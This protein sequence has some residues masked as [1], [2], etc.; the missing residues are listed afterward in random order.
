[1][2]VTRYHRGSG[3]AT[4]VQKETTVYGEVNSVKKHDYKIWLNDG[5][6][7]YAACVVSYM[8]LCWG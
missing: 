4:S 5:V 2:N 8:L 3:M 7:G 6:Y 1:M